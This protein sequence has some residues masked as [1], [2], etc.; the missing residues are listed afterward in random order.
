MDATLLLTALATRAGNRVVLLAYSRRV[1]A[2]V[3]GRG[4]G[5]VL[6]AV[7]DALTPL[8]PEL[9]ETDARGLVAA[10]LAD[11]PRRSLIVFLLITLD[12]APV[13]EGLVPV[14]SQLTQRHTVLLAAV[15]DPHIEEMARS[16]GTVDAIYEA[17]AG[18]EAPAGRRRTAEQL[19]RHG[20]VVVDAP[21]D[22]LAPALAD[23]YLA[24]KAAGRL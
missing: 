1:R 3:Q 15:S 13:D 17:A 23:A 9:A 2:G 5:E 21:P 7:V 22:S 14:L 12:A 6:S 19:R 11:A 4:A 16:R 18:A 8:E 20:V 10:A 24:L